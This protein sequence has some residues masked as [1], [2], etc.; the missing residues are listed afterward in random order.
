MKHEGMPTPRLE[1]KRVEERVGEGEREGERESACT[2][3]RKRERESALAPPFMFLPPPGPALCK[4]G[5]ARSA[6]CSA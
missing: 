6:V 4:L 5:L 2:R 1:E 3:E